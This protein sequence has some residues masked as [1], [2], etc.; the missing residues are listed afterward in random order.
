MFNRIFYDV[1]FLTK[2]NYLFILYI[3]TIKKLS[4]NNTYFL[5]VIFIYIF[6]IISYNTTLL[7][8]L[9]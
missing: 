9:N 2:F 6:N 4:I 7:I 3:F 1:F 5:Q 8:C